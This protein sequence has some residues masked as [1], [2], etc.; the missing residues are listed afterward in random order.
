MSKI[1]IKSKYVFEQVLLNE[2]SMN[3]IGKINTEYNIWT[4]ENLIE[5]ESIINVKCI[6]DKKI[7]NMDYKCYI[8]KP[9]H[10]LEIWKY[11]NIWSIYENK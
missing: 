4:S 5:Y 11:K 6:Y 10:I 9:V 2:K 3:K 7:V 8:K 1:I